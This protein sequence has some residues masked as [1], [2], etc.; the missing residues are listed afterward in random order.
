MNNNRLRAGIIG[1][2]RMGIRHYQAYD[3]VSDYA[4]VVAVCDILSDAVAAFAS[5]Y[6][7]V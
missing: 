7:N 1:L 2:G 6:P 4:N 3:A 5:S